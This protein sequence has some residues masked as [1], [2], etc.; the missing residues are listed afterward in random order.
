MHYTEDLVIKVNKL[1]EATI[2]F[3]DKVSRNEDARIECGKLHHIISSN[4]KNIDSVI[5][6]EEP[7]EL[8]CQIGAAMSQAYRISV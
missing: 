2:D 6:A 5:F 3:A 7:S 1:K 8:E 4:W